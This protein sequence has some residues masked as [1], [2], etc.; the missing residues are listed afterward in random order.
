MLKKSSLA[1]SALAVLLIAGCETPGKPNF[2][3]EQRFEFPLLQPK[4]FY[5]LG[6]SD[7]FIDTT[8]NKTD[9]LF[10]VGDNDVVF[11]S[12]TDSVEL[13]NL[14]DAI[15]SI[16]IDPSTVESEVGRIEVDDFTSTFGSAIGI[17]EQSA[18]GMDP[19]SAEVGNI[20][21][22]F[23]GNGSSSFFDI[24]GQN[25]PNAADPLVGSSQT[26]TIDLSAGTFNSAT[27]VS[28]GLL[29]D[30]A[31]NLGFNIASLTAQ[32]VTDADA[33]PADLGSVLQFTNISHGTDVSGIISFNEGDVLQTDLQIRI[34]L[35]WDLQ[36]YQVNALN[37][38]DVTASEENLVVSEANAEVPAQALT[39]TTPDIVISD[40]GFIS[41]T[42]GSNN[43][44]VN[45]LVITVQ[46]GT[47]L[48]LTNAAFDNFPTLTLKNSNGDVLDVAKEIR[49]ANPIGNALNA[50]E[51][52]EVT[53]DLANEVLTKNLSFEL[54]MGTLGSSGGTI[55]VA[56]T[57]AISITA[58]TSA[59]EVSI[60]NAIIDPQTGIELSDE[61]AIDGDFARAEVADGA[62]N[63]IFSNT[64]SIP[65]TI[66][67][68]VIS[69][70]NAFVTKNTS[71]YIAA[72]TEIGSL[73]NIVIPSNSTK[74]ESIDLAG[75]AIGDEIVFVATASS[76]GSNGVTTSLAESDEITIDVTGSM[77]VN[78]AE[79]KLKPQDFSSTDVITIDKENFEF[80]DA[81]H[82]VKLKSG[83][84]VIDN[85]INGLD[86]NL[87]TLTISV[88]AIK[89]LDGNPL[90]IGFYGETQHGT[91]Y[92]KI[93]RKENGTRAPVVVDLTGYTLVA[94]NNEVAYDVYGKTEDTNNSTE[95][96]RVIKS[97]DKVSATLNINSLEIEEAF[98]KVVKKEILLGDDDASNGLDI[99]DLR[100]DNE[101]EVIE[102]DGLDDISEKLENLQLTGASLS[103]QYTTNIGARAQVVMAIAG[104]DKD[105]N[106]VYLQGKND[107]AVV[108]SDRSDLLYD[109][110]VYL[111]N[112]NLVKFSFGTNATQPVNSYDGSITFNSTNSNVDEFLSKL[113][114]KIRTLGFAVVN[115]DDAPSTFIANPIEFK[116]E[117]SI[118][119]PLSITT[120]GDG[121]SVTEDIG[122]VDIFGNV[123][124]EDDKL[125]L[126]EL[127]MKFNYDNG[128]PLGINLAFEFF[129]ENS[130]TLQIDYQPILI[131]AAPID[132][133]GFTTG[134]NEG[135]AELIFNN[136][137]QLNQIK[138]MHLKLQVETSQREN[139]R[140]RTTDY[141]SVGISASSTGNFK[142]N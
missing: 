84:L 73:S 45:Q 5:F 69:N 93:A 25:A 61:S 43:Q 108:D 140:I 12:F 24:T 39:P 133:N 120:S 94:P 50:G 117:L 106:L 121:I 99:L 139:V 72:G 107:F 125:N 65:M 57:D 105:G 13:G 110:G 35:T 48:P 8:A 67:T 116:T 41:A 53:F 127:K 23:S 9:T 7:A 124:S 49:P 118:D 44:S 51:T 91:I 95:P 3:V 11:I 78:E 103:I 131:E 129:D 115:P 59:L 37:S 17:I 90:L 77:S 92:P 42:L 16:D 102:N 76:D 87:D 137:T 113:P 32:L 26:I 6:G 58:T 30:F 71:R 56:N 114:G 1:T 123:P 33:N 31:N 38:L 14:D 52:A 68:L 20:K 111:P 46:N 135:S 126:T 88:P 83:E 104:E 18:E 82:Y 98:G 10:A 142:Q 136:A 119:I 130:D 28:G 36:N 101:A 80:A 70:K 54:D 86:V 128:L 89:D 66:E 141:I 55:S 81:S 63:L 60:A 4:Q 138:S 34:D 96:F 40:P 122:E 132:A 112:E 134:G 29:I 74:T 64:L 22:E 75:V 47:Q 15:P 109:G 97:T 21:P 2:E 100:N 79:A 19:T 62:L 27:I 85:L